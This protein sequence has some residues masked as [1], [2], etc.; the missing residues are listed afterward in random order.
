MS[1]I[2][3]FNKSVT[4]LNQ[5]N[6]RLILEAEKGCVLTSQLRPSDEKLVIDTTE[7]AVKFILRYADLL[8]TIKEVDAKKK[9]VPD[10]DYQ[11]FVRVDIPLS[12][13]LL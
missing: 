1:T 12:Y 11:E 10:I 9:T 3:E 8:D 2:R 7:A 4:K 5:Y 13:S 6:D